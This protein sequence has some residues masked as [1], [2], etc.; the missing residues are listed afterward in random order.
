L[1]GGFGVAFDDAQEGAGRGV[2]LAAGLF[3]VSQGGEWD[4]Q[5][6]GE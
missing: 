2:G 1:E 6:L 5:A 3:P 4:A